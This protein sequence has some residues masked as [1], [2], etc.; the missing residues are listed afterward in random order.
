MSSHATDLSVYAKSSSSSYRSPAN[1][2]MSIQETEL[3]VDSENNLGENAAATK[4]KRRSSVRRS[5]CRQKLCNTVNVMD[6]LLAA[7]LCV[8]AG[9]G[10]QNVIAN[11]ANSWCQ[12]APF[13]RLKGSGCIVFR[14]SPLLTICHQSVSAHA[15]AVIIPAWRCSFCATT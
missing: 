3:T 15:T 4:H 5:V 13:V 1:C 10:C 2:V 7:P 8:N 9:I 12:S 6:C 14:S 11:R